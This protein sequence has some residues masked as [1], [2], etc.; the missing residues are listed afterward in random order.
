MARQVY[1][2]SANQNGEY[3]NRRIPIRCNGYRRVMA[4]LILELHVQTMSLV[5]HTGRSL[6]F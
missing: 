4:L 3:R 6:E 5:R 2:I 1:W